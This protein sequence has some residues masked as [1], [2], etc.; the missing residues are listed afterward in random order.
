[1]KIIEQYIYA[2]GQKLP[3]RGRE[4]VKEE[5]RSLILDEIE[6]KFGSDPTEDQVKK[7]IEDFGSPS[8]VARKYSG[9]ALVVARG[10]TDIYFMI[11][12]MIL[13]SMVFAFT[14]VFILDLFTKGLGETTLLKEIGRTLGRIWNG[15]LSGI[16]MMTIV[17]IIISRFFRENRVDLEGDWT[18]EDLKD[19]SLD[20]GESR[21]ES[22]VGIVGLLILLSV[23]IFFP[24][25][26]SY[27]ESSLEKAGIYLG[28]TLVMEHFA[29]YGVFLSLVWIG[30]IVYHVLMLT[31]LLKKS[32]IKMYGL[33]LDLAGI[34]LVL[35]MVL[36]NRLFLLNPEANLPRL[37]GFRAVFLLVLVISSIEM[38]ATGVKALM[39]RAEK[40]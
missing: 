13:V 8:D 15:S 2:I 24:E 10:Y 7:A 5:L 22:I 17:F 26:I 34:L 20:E 25:L 1:M 30:G 28:S 21:T 16:G 3:I 40:K 14:T 31:S 27:S 36:D 6:A 38:A 33:V 4:E 11:F 32:L 37:M 39:K 19:I 23:V 9:D 35:V 18:S 29:I 12:W